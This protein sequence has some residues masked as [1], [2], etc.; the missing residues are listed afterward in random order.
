MLNIESSNKKIVKNTIC[1]H[2]RTILIMLVSLY[3]SGCMK[4]ETLDK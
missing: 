3:T 2:F 1:L 4:P